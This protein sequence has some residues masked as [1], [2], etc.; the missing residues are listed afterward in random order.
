MKKYVVILAAGSGTRFGT[1]NGPKQF[2]K[3]MGKTILEHSI[4]ACDCG[5]FDKIIVVVPEPN[6]HEVSKRMRTYGCRADICVVAGG[7]SRVESCKRGIEAIHDDEAYVVVHNGAQPLVSKAS[8][9]KCIAGL[10]TSDA[11]VTSVP[12]VYTVLKVDDAGHVIDIPDRNMLRQ[13]MGEEGF[14]LSVLRKLFSHGNDICE[15]T[16]IVRIVMMSGLS[17]VLAVE[18]DA[19]NAKITYKSDIHDMEYRLGMTSR[20]E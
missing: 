2:V 10:E 7:T 17:T 1:E 3:V 18:G 15:K 11:V 20:K 9:D 5:V 4:D 14:R 6:V 19:D 16:S 12:C 8:F 13:D